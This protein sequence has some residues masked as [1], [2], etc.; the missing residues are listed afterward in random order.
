MRLRTRPIELDRQ[1]QVTV[2]VNSRYGQR[3]E[4]SSAMANLCVC[5]SSHCRCYSRFL[6]TQAA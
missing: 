6:R 4:S 2:S 5:K 3:A 1:K